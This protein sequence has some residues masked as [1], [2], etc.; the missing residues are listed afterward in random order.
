MD[1]AS[2][3]ADLYEEYESKL[4]PLIVK[5]ESSIEKVPEDLFQ[6]IAQMFDTFAHVADIKKA[7]DDKWRD[8]HLEKAKG[9]RDEAFIKCYKML[10]RIIDERVES[11]V[12]GHEEAE[13][14]VLPLD[15][16]AM[17]SDAR[18]HV[19]FA[20]SESC[21]QVASYREAYEKYKIIEDFMNDYSQLEASCRNLKREKRWKFWFFQVVLPV[22]VGVLFVLIIHIITR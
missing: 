7:N 6:I 2:I 14:R 13:L 1:R 22:V 11:C 21:P 19:R 3:Y 8:K 15:F 5:I 12:K 20:R 9:L 10:I 16:I 17:V 4:R 18:N